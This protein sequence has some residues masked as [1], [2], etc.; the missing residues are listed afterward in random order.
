LEA[1]QAPATDTAQSSSPSCRPLN[2]HRRKEWTS[3]AKA[4][5]KSAVEAT[6]RKFVKEEY[7]PGRK[8]KEIS[9]AV[10]LR[11]V[12]AGFDEVKDDVVYRRIRKL[13]FG[14]L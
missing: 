13:K 5:K 7:R 11:L 8:G 14:L 10:N 2:F 1:R 3:A 4:A 12:A 6:L 9:K